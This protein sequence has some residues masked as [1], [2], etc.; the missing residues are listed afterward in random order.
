MSPEARRNRPWLDAPALARG[1][2]ADSVPHRAEPELAGA[3]GY[4]A[5]P[6]ADWAARA[7]G[8]LGDRE[9]AGLDGLPKALVVR[10]MAG[11]GLLDVFR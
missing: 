3:L 11:R 9:P 1:A 7:L 4:P 8:R 10:A 2:S 5:E 6:P